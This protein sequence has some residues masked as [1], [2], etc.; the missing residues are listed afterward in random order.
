[1]SDDYVNEKGGLQTRNMLEDGFLKNIGKAKGPLKQALA[2]QISKTSDAKSDTTVT[3]VNTEEVLIK[4]YN[5]RDNLIETFASL[6]LGSPLAQTITG[7]INEIGDIINRLG[8]ESDTFDPLS[9]VSGLQAPN[10]QRNAER[11]IENTKDAYTLGNIENAHVEGKSVVVGFNG[12]SGDTKYK[13]VGTIT[14]K[15]KWL[16]IEAVDY[17]YTPGE[18]KM[19]V[20]VTTEDGAWVDKSMDYDVTWELFE[21]SGLE[22]EAKNIEKNATM[23]E[24]PEDKIANNVTDNISDDFLIEER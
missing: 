17:I 6:K 13:A 11:V 21:D 3:N 19:S 7:A 12:Q 24:E 2:K 23:K 16:G 8:G 5:I 15:K 1:M 4:S 14:A 10:M 9:H 22:K 18:G 20:K